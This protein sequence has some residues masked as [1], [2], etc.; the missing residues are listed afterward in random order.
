VGDDIGGIVAVASL[1]QR[2]G[3]GQD[4]KRAEGYA[5]AR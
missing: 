5:S 2:F 1:T 4:K 3:E